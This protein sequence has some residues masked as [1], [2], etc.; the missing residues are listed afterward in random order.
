MQGQNKL[1]WGCHSNPKVLLS[2]LGCIVSIFL[3]LNSHE[4]ASV[5]VDLCHSQQAKEEL[6]VA[7]C[8]S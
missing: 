1:S 4:L 7:I 6:M 5:F 3:V 2:L 8:N